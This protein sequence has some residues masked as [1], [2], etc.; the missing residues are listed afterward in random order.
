[1]VDVMVLGNSL[2]EHGVKAEKVLCIN[3]DTELNSIAD[4]MRSFWQFVPVHH[5]PLPRHLRGSE[6]SRL[7]GVYSKLQTVNIFSCRSLRQQRFLLMDADMLMRANLDDVFANE[8]PAGVIDDRGINGEVLDRMTR[9][10]QH[11][12]LKMVLRTIDM[13]PDNPDAWLHACLRNY[14][15]QQQAMA[16][17]GSASV[18]GRDRVRPPS[19]DRGAGGFAALQMS[20]ALSA[21]PIVTESPGTMA[22]GTQHDLG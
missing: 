3:D 16:L 22:S 19:A 21:A 4:L 2:Q 18:H 13:N 1:M 9:V 6:Q 15:Q 20:P 12:K 7:Q 17:L 10:P 11:A 8:V 5:V 14:E